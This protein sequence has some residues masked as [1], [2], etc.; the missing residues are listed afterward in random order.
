[1]EWTKTHTPGMKETKSGYMISTRIF[2]KGKFIHR[3]VMEKHLGR[4]LRDDECVHHING[5]KKDN[6]IENLSLMTKS[7]HSKLH[8]KT[9]IRDEYRGTFRK[10]GSRPQDNRI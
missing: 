3:L 10:S 7:E 1:M 5:D 2:N 6:R 9:R 8:N 4:K